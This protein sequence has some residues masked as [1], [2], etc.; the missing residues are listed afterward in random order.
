MKRLLLGIMVLWLWL[1]TEA[2]VSR[3]DIVRL[4]KTLTTDSL[5]ARQKAEELLKR[6]ASEMPEPAAG[7]LQW[8]EENG[9]MTPLVCVPGSGTLVWETGCGSGST[10]VG[11]W[12][13]GKRTG[14]TVTE[15]NQ[16]GGKILVTV[17]RE[18]G[19]RERI[20]MTGQVHILGEHR[21][22]FMK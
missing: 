15:I 7:L 17:L 14:R 11:A 1:P 12:K 16:P 18:M 22:A 2:Q 9:F 10:A 3:P 20:S 19:K 21:L 6:M 4:R 8:D 5:H 13:A